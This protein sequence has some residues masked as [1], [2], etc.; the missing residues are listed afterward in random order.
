MTF[1]TFPTFSDLRM[2][3]G[4]T[5]SLRCQ[6]EFMNCFKQYNLEVEGETWKGCGRWVET[7]DLPSLHIL[8]LV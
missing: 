7:A 4:V 2:F 8:M 3:P 1:V 5:N 6:E